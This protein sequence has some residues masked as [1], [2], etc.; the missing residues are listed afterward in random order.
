MDFTSLFRQQ[1]DTELDLRVFHCW[2]FLLS[3]WLLMLVYELMD[4]VMVI[5]TT[6]AVWKTAILAVELHRV[7]QVDFSLNLCINII[8]RFSRKIKFSHS[9]TYKLELWFEVA[10]RNR[11]FSFLWPRSYCS[12]IN[13]LQGSL[14]QAARGKLLYIGHRPRRLP[15][16]LVGLVPGGGLEPPA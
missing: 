8:S 15:I 2:D 9:K 11:H 16:Y 3:W 14:T 12:T 13:Y 6:S 4:P 1:V 10:A 7:I 5:E